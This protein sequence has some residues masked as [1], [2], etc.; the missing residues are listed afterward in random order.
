M[1]RPRI[2]PFHWQI[3]PGSL[4]P[5]TEPTTYPSLSMGFVTKREAMLAFIHSSKGMRSEP[6]QAAGGDLLQL[7]IV[8]MEGPNKNVENW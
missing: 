6:L 4:D 3:S 2:T 7:C 8:Y 1:S 5:L